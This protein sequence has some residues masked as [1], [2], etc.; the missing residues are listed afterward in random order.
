MRGF[1]YKTTKNNIK[2]EGHSE[3]LAQPCALA[4]G[5]WQPRELRE[6]QILHY[7]F[8]YSILVESLRC[9]AGISATSEQ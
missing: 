8:H 1:A 7:K 9:Y 4:L 3:P 6:K 2:I 5:V